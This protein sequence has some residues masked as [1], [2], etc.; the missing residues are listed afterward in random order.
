VGLIYYSSLFYSMDGGAS[1][2][3]SGGIHEAAIGVG[4]F[5]G[6]AVGSSAL[7][8]LPHVHNAGILA[9]STVLA[10][11]LIP[12]LWIRKRFA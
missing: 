4:I 6:P 11:G 7:Y 2:G 10:L 1:K 8:F 5:G 9:I 12:F 3:K